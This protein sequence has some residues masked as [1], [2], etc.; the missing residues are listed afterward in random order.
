MTDSGPN[1]VSVSFDGPMLRRI[2]EFRRQY[3]TR[4]GWLTRSSAIRLLVGAGLGAINGED[5]QGDNRTEPSP[6]LGSQ[7]RRSSKGQ[8]ARST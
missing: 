4:V 7:C 8:A 6:S 3:M 2:E 1:S 5:N